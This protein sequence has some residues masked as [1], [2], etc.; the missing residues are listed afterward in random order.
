MHQARSV[1]CREV[2]LDSVLAIRLRSRHQLGSNSLRERPHL[3]FSFPRYWALPQREGL[4]DR[5]KY[6]AL[7]LLDEDVPTVLHDVQWRT[8]PSRRTISPRIQRIERHANFAGDPMGT[9]IDTSINCYRS[10]QL[11]R[12]WIASALKGVSTS[13]RPRAIFL[14]SLSVRGNF[15]KAGDAL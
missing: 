4:V 11:D 5:G 14:S 3:F 8:I 15:T 12:S 6:Q 9:Y 7:A 13:V 10:F 1:L 2:L